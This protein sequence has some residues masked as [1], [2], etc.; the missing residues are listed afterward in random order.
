M[1]S[2][3]TDMLVSRKPLNDPFTPQ[4]IA[5]ADSLKSSRNKMIFS[6]CNNLSDEILP[7]IKKFV[8]AQGKHIPGNA[9]YKYEAKITASETFLY[10]RFMNQDLRYERYGSDRK[11]PYSNYNYYSIP[12]DENYK[13]MGMIYVILEDL[14]R[15]IKI[16][17]I[18]VNDIDVIVHHSVHENHI[19]GVT[20]EM[21]V[22]IMLERKFNSL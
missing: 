10:A 3:L 4:V 19:R 5:Y 8:I 11:V 16:N 13:M 12:W 7:K 18:E 14:S 17:V 22:N 9:V 20:A 2:F 1:G 6:F 15:K 21:T